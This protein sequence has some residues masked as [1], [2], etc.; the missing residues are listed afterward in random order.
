MIS[1]QSDGK[2]DEEE[3][4]VDEHL[5]IE[6]DVR[7]KGL[8]VADITTPMELIGGSEPSS[9]K[10][11]EDG[12]PKLVEKWGDRCEEPSEKTEQLTKNSNPTM[13]KSWATIVKGNRDPAK[14]MELK[15][16]PPGE[17]GMAEITDLDIEEGKSVWKNAVVGYILGEKPSFKEV[18]GFVHRSWGKI[19][20][21]RIHFLKPRIFLFNFSTD[22]AKRGVLARHWNFNKS[23]MVLKEWAPYFKL[24]ECNP[25]VIHVWIQFLGPDRQIWTYQGFYKVASLVGKPIM[26]D[27]LTGHREKLDMLEFLWKSKLMVNQNIL[28]PLECLMERCIRREL[29]MNGL[30]SNAL[31]AMFGVMKNVLWEEGCNG[32]S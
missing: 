21:P 13:N 16:V 15:Y 14:G 29:Y 28:S 22:K 23:P 18:V 12:N 17:D 31:F 20:V 2:L 30:L 11:G 7:G 24:S 3:R 4:S 8:L 10:G 6:V 9:S 19:Q 27:F 26:A 5:S 25:E 32:V 1:D